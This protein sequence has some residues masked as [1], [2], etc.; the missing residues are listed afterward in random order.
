M[1]FDL[2][3]FFLIDLDFELNLDLDLFNLSM[4]TFLTGIFN[5]G[6]SITVGVA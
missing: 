3:A 4:L 5:F 2:D 6:V 1:S